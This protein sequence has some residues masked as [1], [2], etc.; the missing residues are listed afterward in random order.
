MPAADEAVF[1]P[2]LLET[3]DELK[4]RYESAGPY[5]HC[6]INDLCNP[7]LLR[8][9]G[10]GV[11]GR[12]CLPLALACVHAAGPC[13]AAGAASPSMHPAHALFQ[14]V[15]VREEIIENV[16]AT[17]KET[18]LF[19]MFQTG[20]LAN[21]DALPAE[22]GQRRRVAAGATHPTRRS[23]VGRVLAKGVLWWSCG[24]LLAAGPRLV[25]CRRHPH[26]CSCQAAHRAP[27]A[28]RHLRYRVPG[29][30]LARDGWVGG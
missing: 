25:R 1:R 24:L 28:R 16:E 30:H 2:G 29:V 5:P 18:D 12:P 20:D 17:Y 3:R 8:K 4:A 10:A 7:E 6:A 23:D 19:K 11:G 21:L 14:P 13:R 15:Q 22:Q 27:P 9:V 26:A